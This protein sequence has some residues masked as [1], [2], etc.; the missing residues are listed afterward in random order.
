MVEVHR[1][2]QAVVLGGLG[3]LVEVTMRIVPTFNVRQDVYEKVP[4]SRLDEAIYLDAFFSEAYSVSVFTD[5]HCSGRLP[6]VWVKRKE[7]LST[8]GF[9]TP[10]PPAP[11]TLFAH[12][13]GAS[14]ALATTP[15]H[16]NRAAPPS[17]CTLQ[18]EP[19]GPWC[20]R[21]SHFIPTADPSDGDFHLHSEY[22]VSRDDAPEAIRALRGVGNFQVMKLLLVYVELRTVAADE[23]WL[24]PA[25]RRPSL[26]IH[27]V[28]NHDEKQ[29]RMALRTIESRLAPFNPRPKWGT[30]FNFAPEA[31]ATLYPKMQAYRELVEELDSKGK[32]RD[33]FV[34][35]LVL[36]TNGEQEGEGETGSA[37]SLQ[38]QFEDAAPCPALGS[39][40]RGECPRTYDLVHGRVG[41]RQDKLADVPPD[42]LER[43]RLLA[44]NLRRPG[45]Q[46]CYQA[47]DFLDGS[48]HVDSHNL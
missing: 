46:V 1:D 17:E 15:R 25:Y 33:S 2:L 8:G 41:A 24:S 32:F 34:E 48:G 35:R 30:V 23:L 42:V 13:L 3:I 9:P 21:L 28:W 36:G 20:E 31:V 19:A 16:P 39:T 43:E 4:W 27:F 22:F 26:A 10:L 38:L 5:F 40:V 12:A 29:V 11:T 14:G 37:P 18:G 6:S 45:G 47:I 7:E 44:H